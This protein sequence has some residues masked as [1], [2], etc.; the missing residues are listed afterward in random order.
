MYIAKAPSRKIQALVGAFF[1]SM[2]FGFS[3]APA[4]ADELNGAAIL[5]AA[6]VAAPGNSDLAVEEA[7][8]FI[9]SH[10]EALRENQVQLPASKTKSKRV[11]EKHVYILGGAEV[12][13]M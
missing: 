1:F 11:N 10:K 8:K 5:N 13:P 3:L 2:S 4:Q 9:K 12:F 6:P 7:V